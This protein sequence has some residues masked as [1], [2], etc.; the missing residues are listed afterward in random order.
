MRRVRLQHTLV[1]P[2]LHAVAIHVAAWYRHKLI[3]ERAGAVPP[4]HCPNGEVWIMASPKCSGSGSVISMGWRY[5]IVLVHGALESM[6]LPQLPQ[7]QRKNLLPIRTQRLQIQIRWI[8][9]RRIE[10]IHLSIRRHS[11]PL[12]RAACRT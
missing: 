6:Q 11:S 10:T 2:W 4:E 9:Y 3:R 1:A 5:C 12:A 8:S 7:P